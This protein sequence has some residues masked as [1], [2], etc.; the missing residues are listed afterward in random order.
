VKPSPPIDAQASV[1]GAIGK[2]RMGIE[3][4]IWRHGWA[5][6]VAAALATA[7]IATE[8][9][10][11]VPLAR[12]IEHGRDEAVSRAAGVLVGAAVEQPGAIDTA[13]RIDALL[14]AEGSFE[15]QFRRLVGVADKHGIVL[16]RGDYQPTQSGPTE[17]QR[18]QVALTVGA[19][20]PQLRA[21]MDDA[22]RELPAISL[23]QL[24]VKRDKADKGQVEVRMKLTF[25]LGKTGAPDS[26][27]QAVAQRGPAS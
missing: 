7:A 2:V 8:L 15:S 3:L 21:F 16:A 24:A 5:W 27:P 13:G 25:W 11:N 22:L 12:K 9:V 19:R 1:Q 26:R 4:A 18:V 20:Y 23:D 14:R 6:M 17:P 10:L